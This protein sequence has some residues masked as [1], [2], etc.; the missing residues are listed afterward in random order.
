MPS[1][2]VRLGRTVHESLVVP[3]TATDYAA[4]E[5]QAKTLAAHAKK[6]GRR[7]AEP[8]QSQWCHEH[9]DVEVIVIEEA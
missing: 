9:E 4:A 5:Q 3:V 2:H 7:F 1:Y 8:Y 6:Y